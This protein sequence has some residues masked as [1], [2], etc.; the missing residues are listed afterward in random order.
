MSAPENHLKR[1]KTKRNLCVD[2]DFLAIHNSD[3]RLLIAAREVLADVKNELQTV[4]AR[5][6]SP[7][8]TDHVIAAS[9][10]EIDRLR[11]KQKY[12]ENLIKLC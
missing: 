4:I 11:D 2:P 12:L 1:R 5:A 10:T 6:S 3:M 7:G 9:F 8:V